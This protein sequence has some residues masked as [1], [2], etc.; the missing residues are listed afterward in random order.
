MSIARQL[1]SAAWWLATPLIRRYLRKRARKAPAY[2]EH[3]D[4]RFAI[5]LPARGEGQ[6]IWLH[7]V[8]VGETRAAQPLIALLRERYPQARWLITQMTPTGRDTARQLYPF[9]EIRYLPYDR[10]DYMQRFVAAMRPTFGILMETELWPNLMHACR[11]QQIPLFLCNARL[12]EKSLRGYRR[13]LPLIRPAMQ[14]LT[15]VAAQSE[16]DA[17][18]LA[19]LG[20]CNITVCGNTKYDISPPPAQLALGQQFK[21]RIGDRP[22]L[23][24]ASTR[25]GEEA[26]ILDAWR[27]AEV[28]RSLLVIVPRHPERFVAV[29]HSATEKGFAVQCRSDNLP[30]LPDTQVWIG[31]S[32]GE[33]F[34]YYAAADVAFIGGS[35]LDFGSQNLIEPACLGIPILIGPSTYNFSD[36]AENAIR[37]GIAIRVHNEKEILLNFNCLILNKLVINNIK[38]AGDGFFKKNIGASKIQANNIISVIENENFT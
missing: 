25:E 21:Q 37:A 34:A 31:D 23:V 11:T 1:Y 27:Q 16:D 38:I 17:Q 29:A 4:E 12:S 26:L 8:S 33:L 24:C 5:D 28:G 7:A 15:A 18:R 30:L 36:A 3:W 35:L 2:L 9:A 6:L 14:A 19:Q 20:A 32:M 22:V 13:I 10:A